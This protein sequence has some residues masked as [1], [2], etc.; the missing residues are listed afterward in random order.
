M[1]YRPVLNEAKVEGPSVHPCEVQD[2]LLTGS[3]KCYLA[4]VVE[5]E[6]VL[7]FHPVDQCVGERGLA[8]VLRRLHRVVEVEVSHDY[9]RHVGEG[10]LSKDS[11][12][13]GVSVIIYIDDEEGGAAWCP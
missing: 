7:C 11:E 9:D 2:Q 1:T 6:E 12:G 4:W 8:V 13:C 10:G 5:E 3:V